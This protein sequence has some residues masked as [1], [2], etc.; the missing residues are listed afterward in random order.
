MKQIYLYAQRMVGFMTVRRNVCALCRLMILANNYIKRNT[1]Y[2]C[3]ASQ[4]YD[5]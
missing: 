5:I 4:L 3:C 2:G 1:L